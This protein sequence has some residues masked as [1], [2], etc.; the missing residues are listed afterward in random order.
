MQDDVVARCVDV[1]GIDEEPVH[2][3]KTGSH[4]GESLRDISLLGNREMG[5]AG[6]LILDG[7]GNHDGCNAKGWIKRNVKV[8]ERKGRGRRQEME[9]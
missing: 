7:F 8:E 3:K 1:L 2:I 4:F 6:R 5:N 9:R